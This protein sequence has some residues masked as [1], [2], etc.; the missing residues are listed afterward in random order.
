MKITDRSCDKCGHCDLKLN[1]DEMKSKIKCLIHKK[2]V[3]ADDSCGFFC[4]KDLSIA[5]DNICNLPE[6]PTYFNTEQ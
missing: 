5:I 4:G 2:D 6:Y 1:F 3:K